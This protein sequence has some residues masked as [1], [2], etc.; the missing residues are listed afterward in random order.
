MT[1]SILPLGDVTTTMNALAAPSPLSLSGK[2]ATNGNIDKAAQDFEAMFATQMLQP[3]FEGIQVDP[4]FGGGHGEEVM[5]SF[6]LQEY[7][8]M[9][10]KSGRLGIASQ[11]KAEMIR[12]QEGANARASLTSGQNVYASAGQNAY[13]GAATQGASNVSVQ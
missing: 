9:I 7:G 12:A 13:S 1:D 2:M 6:M 5:R 10:A 11:V 8:K 3:M 4:V